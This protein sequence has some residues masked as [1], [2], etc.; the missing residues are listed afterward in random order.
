MNTNMVIQF[1]AKGEWPLVWKEVNVTSIEVT[2][3]NNSTPNILETFMGTQKVEVPFSPDGY[4]LAENTTLEYCIKRL[5]H[6]DFQYK[7]TTVG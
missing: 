1:C 5:E 2:S 3:V 4:P 7:I 6:T